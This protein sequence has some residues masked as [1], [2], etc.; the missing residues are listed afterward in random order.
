MTK[1]QTVP[2]PT[3]DMNFHDLASQQVSQVQ[4]LDP[5]QTH[6]AIYLGSLQIKAEHEAKIAR[7]L[8][9]K[10]LMSTIHTVNTNSQDISNLKQSVSNL[11]SGQSSLEYN[12][13][14]IY[15][16][17]H[18]IHSLAWQ[19]YQM[20]A[21]SK[22]RG[23][24]G[25]FI[26]QGEHVLAHT[27]YEDL[28]TKLFPIIQ[29]KY[30]IFVN[31]TELTELHR[32]PN[33]KIFF[34]LASRLPGQS[35]DKF[36]RQM[37][38][39]LKPHIKI[40][41]TI[42]LFEPYAEL[43]YIARR[44][45]HYNVISNYR[46]DE[47]GNTQIALSPT[48]QSF[49]FTGLDQLQTLQI[50]IPN[51]IKEEIS[52]RR[53]QIRQNEEKSQTL[54]NEKSKKQRPNPPLSQAAPTSTNNPGPPINR[55]HLTGANN[56]P[57]LPRVPAPVRPTPHPVNQPPPSNQGNQLSNFSYQT[58]QDSRSKSVKRPHPINPS[59]PGQAMY[60]TNLKYSNHPPP[61]QAHYPQSS[62]PPYP[63]SF[64]TTPPP[65]DGPQF[66]WSTGSRTQTAG[67]TGTSTV[68]PGLTGSTPVQTG[69]SS[70][71]TGQAE[72]SGYPQQ[73]TTT[74]VTD[75]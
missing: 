61:N 36:T 28:Y 40:Y 68:Q 53:A 12:Q 11:Q 62:Y 65:G 45:K 18:L 54:N 21:E 8:L 35:F 19:S 31:P 57:V 6:L 63:Q 42:Q 22:Q 44:L 27:P 7:H 49:K 15:T 52:Y 32:L 20:A 3:Q 56:T 64:F 29:E 51:Q 75:Y 59:P 48:T 55:V 71:R 43:F 13:S 47:N 39:N 23:S 58:I 60:P 72:L 30:G 16:Q 74:G 4:G 25:N 46:L 37:N 5:S 70:T 34:S 67:L 24:K 73:W 33:G 17:L 1:N 14:D 26:V 66:A 41:V 38:S 69:F 10:S 2:P 50:S 9:E